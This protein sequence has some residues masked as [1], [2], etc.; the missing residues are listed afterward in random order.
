MKI[1]KNCQKFLR[2]NKDYCGPPS[3]AVSPPSKLKENLA[4]HKLKY[5][6]F[7]KI[8]CEREK[9]IVKEEIGSVW[10]S[11]FPD[12][13]IEIIPSGSDKEYYM[14]KSEAAEFT[15]IDTSLTA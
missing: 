10:R 9:D 12:N 7:E 6:F 2:K 5:W 15:W 14:E 1:F 3:D 13:S 8:V 11:S 4:V